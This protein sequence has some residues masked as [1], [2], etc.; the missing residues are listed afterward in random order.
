M[1]RKI[2]DKERIQNAYAEIKR[3]TVLNEE[4]MLALVELD[5][6]RDMDKIEDELAVTELAE[7]ILGGM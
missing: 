4:L 1:F 6:Q 2:T 3:L 7:T 5:T